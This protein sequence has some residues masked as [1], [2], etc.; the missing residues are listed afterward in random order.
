MPAKTP[1]EPLKGD[2]AYRASRTAIA[3]RNAAAC[4]A[5]AQRRAQK[6]AEA[7]E[8]AARQA[9]SETLAARRTHLSH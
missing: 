6:E 3:E 8:E 1:S 7:A 2:A 5:A 4:A 9:R